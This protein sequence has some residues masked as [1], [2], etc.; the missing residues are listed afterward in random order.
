MSEEL[1]GFLVF[2]IEKAKDLIDCFDP[3]AKAILGETEVNTAVHEDGEFNPEWGETF[4][5]HHKG[6][7]TDFVK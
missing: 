6:P 7:G 5:L 1:V 4:K 3:Y 2:T